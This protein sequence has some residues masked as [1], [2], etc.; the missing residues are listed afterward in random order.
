MTLS[1]RFRVWGLDV[2]NLYYK[3]TY[4]FLLMLFYLQFPVVCLPAWLKPLIETC[5]KA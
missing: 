1:Y 3:H 4:K 5:P 2:S